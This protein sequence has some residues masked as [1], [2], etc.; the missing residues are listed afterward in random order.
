VGAVA[1]FAPRKPPPAPTSEVSY[2]ALPEGRHVSDRGSSVFDVD[3]GRVDADSGH[4]ASFPTEGE[5]VFFAGR[6]TEMRTGDP[7]PHAKVTA[8]AE[9]SGERAD[10]LSYGARSGEDGRFEVTAAA[11]FDYVIEASAAGF[12]DSAPQKIAFAAGQRRIPVDVELSRGATVSGRVTEAETG[13]PAADVPVA[14]RQKTGDHSSPVRTGPDGRYVLSGIA[15]GDH[16]VLLDLS[17][18]RYL[19]SGGIPAQ[20]IVVPVPDAEIT[21][22]D[23]VV[24]PAGTV[25]GYVYGPDKTPVAGSDVLLCT[26]ES[27]LTQAIHVAAQRTPPLSSRSDENGYYELIGAPLNKEWR[28]QAMSDALAPQLS[29]PFLLTDGA[30]T[31]RVDVFLGPGTTISGRVVSTR[32]GVAPGADVACLP[33]YSQFAAPMASPKAI[34][35]ARADERGEFV[36]TGLPA[37]EY[38]ILA[39]KE[40]F[41]FA[42]MGE[43]VRPDGV[44]DIRGVEVW[45]TPVASGEHTVFGTI[46]DSFGRPIAAVDVSLT[47]VSGFSVSVNELRATTNAQ[48]FYSFDGIEEGSLFLRVSRDGYAGKTVDAV[49]LDAPTDIVLDAHVEVSGRVAVRETGDAVPGADVRA[50]PLEQSADFFAIAAMTRDV[51]HTDADGR[52]TLRLSPGEY[53]LEA[54]APQCAPGSAQVSL[55]PGRDA[56]GIEIPVSQSGGVIRGR[57][58]SVD[59][60]AMPGANVRIGRA[61]LSYMGIVEAASDSFSGRQTESGAGGEFAFERLAEGSY[62]LEARM[63]G[64]AMGSVGPIAVAAGQRAPDVAIVLGQ[65]GT[66]QGYVAVDGKIREGAVIVLAGN[67]VREMASADQNGQYVIRNVPAGEYLVSAMLLD[68][69][70]GGAFRPM[71]ARVRIREGQTTTQNF[72][73]DGDAPHET[74]TLIAGRCA[75]PPGSGVQGVALLMIPSEDGAQ[76]LNLANPMLWYAPGA[77]SSAAANIQGYGVVGSDG[78]FSIENAPR[79]DF[80]LHVYYL[81]PGDFLRRKIDP[82]HS[83]VV[84]ISGE[85]RLEVQAAVKAA[86]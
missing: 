62:R 86:P 79:G 11:G 41:K 26:S 37:G 69:I 7:V 58:V 1:L 43:P 84:R 53:A 85:P 55:V 35:S 77:A 3:R 54:S 65:G 47:L 74:G 78:T 76:G 27:I 23:F 60:R 45:L 5:R 52:F 24:R 29:R 66:L 71:H 46:S 30:R 14:V 12:L 16:D 70:S 68:D 8:R 19:A 56:S 59:G 72:G 83:Q 36:L 57:V 61:G 81:R 32:G 48:G 31:A 82:V 18:S 50:I 51:A 49:Q 13:R 9:A 42:L 10:P 4:D 6:V 67:G 44:R 38:Q 75:P 80:L 40:G 17:Q 2:A 20:R 63:N 15:P 25:W 21:D 64:Y 33:A 28:V 39:R 22:V 73:Q 34:R